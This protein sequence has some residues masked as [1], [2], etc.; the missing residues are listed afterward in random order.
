ACEMERSNW[1]NRLSTVA[2]FQRLAR[3]K[4]SSTDRAAR[5][6][7]CHYLV[8][9]APLRNRTAA[10]SAVPTIPYPFHALMHVNGVANLH[11][12]GLRRN[13][14]Q[15]ILQSPG[16]LWPHDPRLSTRSS[17]PALRHER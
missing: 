2:K 14:R 13:H 8:S 4:E 17:D 15:P 10:D 3:G 16:Q 7:Q 5:G 6:K 11:R 12:T 1:W 9:R